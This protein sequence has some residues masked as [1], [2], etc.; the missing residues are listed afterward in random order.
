M[1]LILIPTFPSAIDMIT[2]CDTV[3]VERTAEYG[4]DLSPATLRVIAVTFLRDQLGKY[5]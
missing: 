2:N 5:A 1:F 4:S 3:D